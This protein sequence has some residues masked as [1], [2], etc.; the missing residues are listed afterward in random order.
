MT[1]NLGVV[2]LGVG[3]TFVVADIP[4]IIEGAHE[5]KGL[6]LRFL[7]HIERTRT[8]AF[9]VPVDADDPQ[10]EYGLLRSELEAHS[11]ELA[12][13]PHCVI[14]TK[15]DLLPPEASPPVLDAPDAWG[16]FGVSAVSRRGLA[17]LLEALWSRTR[18]AI[19]D[20]EGE[21]AE[22]QWMP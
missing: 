21:P 19:A 7:R 12:E 22:E 2:Q 14:L 13:K 9:M 8:L 6:G 16:V 10:S 18:T 1:P 20:S 15:M 17:E 11:H 3:R 4:G 5:G